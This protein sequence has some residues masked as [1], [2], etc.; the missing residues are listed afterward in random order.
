MQTHVEPDN[1]QL[2]LDVYNKYSLVYLKE[3]LIA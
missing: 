1:S 3:S 2:I